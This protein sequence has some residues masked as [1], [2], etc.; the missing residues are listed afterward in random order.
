MTLLTEV[1]ALDKWCPLGRV[2]EA[3]NDLKWFSPS[4][5]VLVE[6]DPEDRANCDIQREEQSPC[7]A[8]RC[9]AW[10][11]VQG[12][13]WAKDFNALL[14][15]DNLV[16]AIK[17]YRNVTGLG[18]KE[19]KEYCDRVRDGVEPM[20]TEGADPQGYCGAFGRPE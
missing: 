18:L 14:A 19:A 17:L 3:N 9:M 13:D 6:S 10:R 5:N 15:S 20:P 7:V 1:E 11:W 4:S 2:S 8:S 12:Y 16:N